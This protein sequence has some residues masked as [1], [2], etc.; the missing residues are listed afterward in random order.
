MIF[1]RRR[2]DNRFQHRLFKADKSCRFSFSRMQ[3]IVLTVH[4]ITVIKEGAQ[5]KL[6]IWWLS[7]A[8]SDGID[9]CLLL[10]IFLHFFMCLFRLN[11]PIVH[12]FDCYLLLLLKVVFL[13]Y[14]SLKDA[15]F[16]QT[17]LQHELINDTIA[18]AELIDTVLE[19]VLCHNV[20]SS[21]CA[22]TGHSKG[23]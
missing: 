6:G 18:K 12:L 8:P 16:E 13:E 14:M 1:P 22:L 9:A 4:D 20:A 19:V 21:N 17:M 15:L 11:C 5:L 10:I 3:F 23:S 2:F 7:R